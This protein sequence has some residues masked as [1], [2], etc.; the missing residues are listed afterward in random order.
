MGKTTGPHFPRNET[1]YERPRRLNRQLLATVTAPEDVPAP[2]H[3][4]RRD[5]GHQGHT[6][7]A[8]FHEVNGGALPTD[9]KAVS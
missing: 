2:C 1:I 9:A 4:W 7:L 3:L 8:S 5:N 6:R